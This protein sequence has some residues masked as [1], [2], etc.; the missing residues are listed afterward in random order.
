MDNN[1]QLQSI[2]QHYDNP[3]NELSVRDYIIIFRIRRNV[4]KK[5]RGFFRVGSIYNIRFIKGLEYFVKGH[6]QN[7]HEIISFINYCKSFENEDG[8]ITA[9]FFKKIITKNAKFVS[10]PFTNMMFE[11][12]EKQKNKL[13]IL[14]GN[15]VTTISDKKDYLYRPI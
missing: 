15:I 3:I 5:L 14:I 4:F 6:E 11:I 9:A 2:N 7:Q 13:K 1:T 10:G 8:Y 12:I